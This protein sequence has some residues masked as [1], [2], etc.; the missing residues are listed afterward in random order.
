MSRLIPMPE[1]KDERV[2]AKPGGRYP[3]L[4][5]IGIHGN[6]LIEGPC[7]VADW[8][9]E[10]GIGLDDAIDS[11]PETEGVYRGEAVFLYRPGDGWEVEDDSHFTFENARLIEVPA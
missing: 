3:I 5:A 6:A 8:L 11:L 2:W 7:E 10:F 9:R 4:I 1:Q